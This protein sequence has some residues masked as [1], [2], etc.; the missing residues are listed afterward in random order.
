MT[1][2]ERFGRLMHLAAPGIIETI[3]P[4]EYPCSDCYMDNDK[5]YPC[6]KGNFDMIHYQ[7]CDRYK[8]YHEQEARL[9]EI[10][11]YLSYDYQINA[12]MKFNV[13]CYT[14]ESN[15][16]IT[17]VERNDR[18]DLVRSLFL[19][20]RNWKHNTDPVV[21]LLYKRSR[22]KWD[23]VMTTLVLAGIVTSGP[24]MFVIN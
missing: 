23:A 10:G 14:F 18:T 9:A 7:D 3:E 17:Y 5:H 11:L 12:V 16:Y 4:I 15:P 8:K 19:Y 2:F 13:H 24:D 21:P 22:A 20:T 1:K 6:S